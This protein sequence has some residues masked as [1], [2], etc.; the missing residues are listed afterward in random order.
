MFEG[1]PFRAHSSRG[2]HLD[3][4]YY[5]YCVKRMDDR[6]KTLIRVCYILITYA[7]GYRGRHTAA[8]LLS[9]PRSASVCGT[10]QYV[11]ERTIP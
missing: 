1:R 6:K 5:C 2:V 11:T 10:Q 4:Y 7:F 8:A 3:H 9:L